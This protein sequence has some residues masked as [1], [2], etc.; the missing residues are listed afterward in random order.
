M[1]QHWLGYWLITCLV[2]SHYLNKCWL[3]LIGPLRTNFNKILTE[4]PTF[5]FTAMNMKCHMQNIGYFVQG[6]WVN[7]PCVKTLIYSDG[8]LL[9]GLL[10][11]RSNVI[12]SPYRYYFVSVWALRIVLTLNLWKMLP[13]YMLFSNYLCI[14]QWPANR[15]QIFS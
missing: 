5:S 10:I 2:L 9:F 3:F 13:S 4:I 7:L 1:D 15:H 8:L 12:Y 6:I 11:C 14:I